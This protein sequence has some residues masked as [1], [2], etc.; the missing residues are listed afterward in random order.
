MAYLNLVPFP[1]DSIHDPG[2]VLPRTSAVTPVHMT[3]YL[4]V[5]IYEDISR[6]GIPEDQLFAVIAAE[7]GGDRMVEGHPVNLTAVRGR[8]TG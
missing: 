8:Q 5:G 2:I 7:V 4:P 1:P 6:R 3:A